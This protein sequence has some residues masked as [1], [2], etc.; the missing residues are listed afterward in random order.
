MTI[1]I[2][3]DFLKSIKKVKR[4]EWGILIF[5]IAERSGTPTDA[6]GKKDAASVARRG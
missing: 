5:E 4:F 3:S 2:I 6:R 1:L